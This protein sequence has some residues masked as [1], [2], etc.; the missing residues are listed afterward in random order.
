MYDV[1][2]GMALEPMQGNWVSSPFDLGYTELFC[3]PVVTSVFF[4]T[5]DSVLGH[6]AVPSSKSRLLKCL[7]GNTELLCTQ[8]SGI[9][10]HLLE[11]GKSHGLS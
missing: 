10:P 6:S 11:R 4:Q 7:I 9:A 1:E 8:C 2:H 5:C 3:D